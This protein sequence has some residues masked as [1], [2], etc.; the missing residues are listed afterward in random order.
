MKQVLL[1]FILIF[2][3]L[4]SVTVAVAQSD[5][6]L[7]GVF[8]GPLTGGTPK[9]VELYVINDIADLSIY[10]I[11]SANNGGGTDGEEF[12]FPAGTVSAGEYIYLGHEGSNTGSFA[13][14]F[15]IGP[16]FLTSAV[17]VNGDD[18]IELFMNGSV[19]DVFGDSGT[20]GTNQGWE[21][22][23]GWA[24]R[25]DATGPDGSAW[26]ISNWTFSGINIIDGATTNGSSELPFPVRTYS[27]A[28]SMFFFTEDFE[29]A[30][31]TYIATPSDDLS[32]IADRQY[33]GRI[34]RPGGLPSAVEY[35]NLQGGAFYSAED[36]DDF[37]NNGN[38]LIVLDFDDIDI[39]NRSMIEFCVSI[40][41]DATGA[42]EHWDTNSSVRFS[43]EID[44]DGTEIPLFAVESSGA[45]NTA[46]AIDTNGDGTGNGAEITSIFR[47]YCFSI[48]ET[49][50]LMDLKIEIDKLNNGMEDIAIDNVRLKGTDVTPPPPPPA[51]PIPTMG[52]WALFI[53]ALLMS[54]LGVV[55]L[56]NER[57]IIA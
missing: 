14:F 43:Y 47:E 8:D 4:C 37:P 24:Y 29:D 30:T 51:D 13:T 35:N 3:G 17:N 16:D 44:N 26:T 25:M 27:E 23:D 40:A 56:Y 18:A 53:L 11:G 31:L 46:P 19:V 39:L 21:Y 33:Y 41:E 42:S 36:T 2:L 10:G 12:T 1:S 32:A 54:S 34:M 50:D 9:A 55:F 48:P 57:N 45:N 28:A 22:L 7:T 38:D 49:G 6:V 20:D 52:Q 15:G 5:L